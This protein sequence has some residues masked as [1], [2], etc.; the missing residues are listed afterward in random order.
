VIDE[1]AVTQCMCVEELWEGSWRT[2]CALCW[3]GALGTGG[4][5]GGD[6]TGEM[7]CCFRYFFPESGAPQG[8]KAPG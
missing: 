1:W 7:G 3:A 5:G 2:T 4:L 8:L 6:V